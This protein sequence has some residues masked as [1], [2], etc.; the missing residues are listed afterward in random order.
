[1]VEAP[2]SE[3]QEKLL[4]KKV[5]W[6]A[7]VRPDGR[8]HLVPVWF[9]WHADHFYFSTAPDSVKAHNMDA[10]PQVA[11]A[12]E[13][14]TNPVICEGEAHAVAMPVAAEIADAFFRKYEWNLGTEEHFNQIYEVTPRRWVGM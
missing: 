13:D 2:G 8:P 10:N 7:S 11:V 5:L 6:I 1:M 4:E 14:G 3:I 12:L 9:I